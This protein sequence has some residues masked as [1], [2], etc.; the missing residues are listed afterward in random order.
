MYMIG[1]LTLLEN[2]IQKALV[3]SAKNYSADEFEQFASDIGYASWMDDF[4]ENADDEE[5]TEADVER[6]NNVLHEAFTKA[7]EANAMSEIRKMSGLKR[8]EF[9]RRYNIPLRTME[10]WEAGKSTPAEYVA[11]LLER[12]VRQDFGLPHT[13]Y[14][15]QSYMGD[16][17][18]ICKTENIFEARQ[19]SQDAHCREGETTE[20]RLYAADVEDEECKNFDYD[21]IDF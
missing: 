9:C 16:E 1:S 14:V 21:I 15:V 2:E 7:H 4:I 20:I 5:L 11:A 6:I 18:T 10:D 17:W 19:A 13:Y 12:A 8:A 3:N